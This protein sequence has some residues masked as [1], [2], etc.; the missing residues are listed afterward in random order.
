MGYVALCSR[1]GKPA[2]R[3]G[4]CLPEGLQSSSLPMRPSARSC[5][6]LIAQRPGCVAQPGAFGVASLQTGCFCLIHTKG[7]YRLEGVQGL[8]KKG[9][10]STPKKFAFLAQSLKCAGAGEVGEHLPSMGLMLG[11][12]NNWKL[13]QKSPKVY[14]SK[15]TQHLSLVYFGLSL[16]KRC[17]LLKGKANCIFKFKLKIA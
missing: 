2:L 5:H 13:T 12:R 15:C 4:A 10:N 11:Q 1:Q 8:G 14:L 3:K 6:F 7:S 16:F 17:H 9:E